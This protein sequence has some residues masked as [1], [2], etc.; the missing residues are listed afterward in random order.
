L[1]QQLKIPEL[2]CCQLL[3][4]SQVREH[5]PFLNASGELLQS[6]KK[7]K[8]WLGPSSAKVS[9]LCWKQGELFGSS[10]YKDA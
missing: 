1:F 2:A 4:T 10:G 5:L 9:V 6:S 8:C 3:R 7:A